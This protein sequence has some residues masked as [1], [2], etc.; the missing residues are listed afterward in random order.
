MRKKKI[1]VAILALIV[2]SGAGLAQ[3]KAIY[4]EDKPDSLLKAISEMV[5]EENARKDSITETIQKKYREKQKV[6]RKESKELISNLERVNKPDGPKAFSKVWHN[7]PVPQHYSG[8]CWCF[9]TTSFIESE[10]K[11]RYDKEVK[12]SELYTVYWEYVEKIKRFIKM[13]GNSEFGQ[14][15]ES[16]AVFYRMESY[17]AV[18]KVV[19]DGFKKY[20]KHVHNQLF[21]DLH[22]YLEYCKEEN[23]WNEEVIIKTVRAILDH[24]IGRPP[25]TFTYKGKQYTP[26]SFYKDFMNISMSE[27]AGFMSTKSA[28]FYKQAE[29]EVPDNWWNDSTYYNVPL[30]EWYSIVEKSIKNGYSVVIGGDVS[31]PGKIGEEDVAFIPAFDI[32][33]NLIDQNSRE[34]RI[35]N[36]T[37]TDD[38]GIHIVGYNSNG[39]GSIENDWFLIKDSARSSRAGQYHGY[40]MFR[41]D[42]V[43]LKM[44][45]FMVHKDMVKDVLKKFEE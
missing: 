41:G 18:P 24:Y 1:F 42:F 5:E 23:F 44:L 14:G 16:N 13:R 27:Y 37:T 7:P 26:K 34:H 4:R 39:H 11:R 2:L 10:L 33:T 38:H 8:M 19:Y 12:L 25:E 45:T 9:C 28:P 31:E 17:G 40:Y 36:H 43:K 22:N 29:F 35:Y 30:D 3:N 32:P 15:S 21:R 6:K 20:D